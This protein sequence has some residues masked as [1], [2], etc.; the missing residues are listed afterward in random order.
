[1]RG[2]MLVAV[3]LF[4]ATLTGCG[5]SGGGT[6]TASAPAPAHKQTVKV[7]FV[8]GEQFAPVARVVAATSSAPTGAMEALLAGPT[9]A[10][11]SQGIDTT[12][13]GGATLTSVTVADGT[14]TVDIAHAQTAPTAFDVSL[15]PARA[16]QIV[17]TLTA[18]PGIHDVVIRVNGEDRATFVGSELALQGSLD[19]G[20][21]SRPVTLP[22]EPA[23]VPNG[24]A[25]A[26]P[27]AVQRRLVALRYLP[28]GRGHR[29]LGLPHVTGGDG[30]PGVAG[31]R[32]GRRRS[33]RRRWRSSRPRRYPYRRRRRP[34]AGSRCTAARA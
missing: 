26:D 34:A 2:A 6:T 13:P 31:P 21:L 7:Y 33:V 10:E 12:I 25:P 4:A 17:Y 20:D 8:K 5:G 18:I 30:L 16:S 9:A 23:E 15:R 28:A 19:T 24:H 29:N 27:A 14:A 32:P 22:S 1:M 11:R 3:G